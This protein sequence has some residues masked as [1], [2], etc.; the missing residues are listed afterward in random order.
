MYYDP[1]M[2]RKL[3]DGAEGGH[4]A[5]VAQHRRAAAMAATGLALLALA[6]CH[7]KVPA[8]APPALVVAAVVHPREGGSD[9]QPIRYPVEVASRYSTA[10][11]FRVAGK[12]VERQ[13]RLGD[14]V[15]KGQVIARLDAV[16]AQRNAASAQAAADSADH[17][18]VFARQQ[19]DRDRAQSAGNLIAA[20]QLEQTQDAYAAASAAR[21]QA[22]AQR[23]IAFNSLAYNTLAVDH[24][25]V[26]TSENADTGQVV[27]AGQTVYG[28]A[29][30]GDTDVNLDAAASDLGRIQIGQ[31]ATVVFPALPGVKFA[32]R[33]REVAPAADSQS[34]TYR[35][36][37]TLAA[38][39]TAVRLGM[40]GDATLAPLPTGPA[41]AADPSFE[42][43][44][45]AIF[46]RGK[47]PAVWVL[48]PTD[49]TLELRA[50]TVRSYGERSA[51]IGGGLHD[52]ETV[53]LAGVHT[54]FMGQHVTATQP[55]FADESQASP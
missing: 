39:G 53:V 28:F 19:L 49:S 10:L 47:E 46:H 31:A 45:T 38:P 54:V 55:L 26:I 13:V 16:D 35:V 48:R 18:L 3:R 9:G 20:N 4:G 17:R 22:A 44:A 41:G 52:G 5:G 36:K 7:A 51:I 50:V 21:E 33:V 23:T 27:A 24:D 14:S 15:H 43:P 12:I 29:W 30:S 6:G 34:R 11:S 25:G 1:R 42:V 40:T 37:L 32:A 2:N 8:A